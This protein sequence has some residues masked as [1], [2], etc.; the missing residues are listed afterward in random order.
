MLPDTFAEDDLKV[1]LPERKYEGLVV[2]ESTTKKTQEQGRRPVESA[3]QPNPGRLSHAIPIR[4]PAAYTGAGP[5]TRRNQEALR[6][7]LD[8]VVA[9][10][11]GVTGSARTGMNDP[12]QARWPACDE[13]DE[14]GLL[15]R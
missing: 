7:N 12:H 10:S 3:V 4:D 13:P 9:S 8:T 2:K 14:E 11:Q 15:Q 6:H 1:D 5:T